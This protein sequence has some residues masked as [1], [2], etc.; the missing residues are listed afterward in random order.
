[1]E[2]RQNRPITERRPVILH[3]GTAD[4][5]NPGASLRA[6]AATRVDEA[7][8]LV[9][10][11]RPT[12]ALKA[13]VAALPIEVQGHVRLVGY[14]PTDAFLELLG[15]C[16]LVVVPSTYRTPVF[17]PTV[18]EAFAAGTPVIA[19]S[20]SA[21][22]IN[23]RNGVALAPGFSE[24]DLALSMRAFLTSAVTWKVASEDAYATAMHLEAGVVASRLLAAVGTLTKAA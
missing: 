18:L 23:G 11:G 3:M 22:L 21:D 5:K 16:M 14:V 12:E 8:E 4:Y 24:E 10:T 20:V 7:Y 9:I 6:F 1:M 19:A 13:Q 15:S 2:G 17:S